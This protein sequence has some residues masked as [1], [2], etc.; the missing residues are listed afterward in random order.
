MVMMVVKNDY[1]TG[2]QRNWQLRLAHARQKLSRSVEETLEE[3]SAEESFWQ[4]ASDDKGGR[5]YPPI[6]QMEGP[7]P[8]PDRAD[9]PCLPEPSPVEAE[10]SPIL[11]LRAEE[12]PKEKI[13]EGQRSTTSRSTSRF[14]RLAQRLTSS[15]AALGRSRTGKGGTTVPDAP[16]QHSPAPEVSDAPV[17]PIPAVDDPRVSSAS[18]N[19]ACALPGPAMSP[20]KISPQPGLLPENLTLHTTMNSVSALPTVARSQ[21]GQGGRQRL[22][23]HTTRI[24]LEIAPISALPEPCFKTTPSLGADRPSEQCAPLSVVSGESPASEAQV[25]PE[26]EPLTGE[27]PDVQAWSTINETIGPERKSSAQGQA[28][29]SRAMLSESELVAPAP[30]SERSVFSP[31]SDARITVVLPAQHVDVLSTLVNPMPITENLAPLSELSMPMPVPQLPMLKNVDDGEKNTPPA[32]VVE[33]E[34]PGP[35]EIVITRSLVPDDLMLPLTGARGEE[36]DPILSGS[37]LFACGQRTVTVAHAQITASSVVLV[38]LAASPGPVVVQYVSLQPG[39]SFTAH[40]T[41]PATMETPFNY[42]VLAGASQ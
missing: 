33:P 7:S 18:E 17:S 12:V 35:P 13:D 4:D 14:A 9:L 25:L 30:G 20:P 22:A 5:E 16:A 39:E 19:D 40:L 26:S 2:T 32:P 3:T 10:L 29:A 15:L 24:R 36:K 31:S 23:G 42:L 27:K 37:G 41:A 11:P 38:M 6:S 34:V 28:F 8:S 1:D 21:L